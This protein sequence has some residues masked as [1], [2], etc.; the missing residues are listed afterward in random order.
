LD[1]SGIPEPK[2]TK[3]ESN[4]PV[5]VVYEIYD[6]QSHQMGWRAISIRPAAMQENEKNENTKLP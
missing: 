4:V 2:C 3:S 6:V 5:T 1:E